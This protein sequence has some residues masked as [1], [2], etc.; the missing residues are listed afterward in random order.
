MPYD[1]QVMLCI[2]LSNNTAA[3][4]GLPAM[5]SNGYTWSLLL[6]MLLLLPC[7]CAPGPGAVVFAAS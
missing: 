3:H 7:C 2:L 6:L 5:P 4:A 1:W